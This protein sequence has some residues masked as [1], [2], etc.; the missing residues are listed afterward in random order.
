MPYCIL[1]LYKQKEDRECFVGQ[2]YD[3]RLRQLSKLEKVLKNIEVIK[4]GHGEQ[5][6]GI[7]IFMYYAFENEDFDDK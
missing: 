4:N 2:N 6:H 3:T 5:I 1:T 7:F